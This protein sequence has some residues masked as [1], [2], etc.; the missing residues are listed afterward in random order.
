LRTVGNR[1]SDIIEVETSDFVRIH[2]RTSYSVTFHRDHKD[3]WFNCENYI[4]VMCDH[5]RSIVRSRTRTMALSQLWPQISQVVRDTILGPRAEGSEGRK[6]RFFAENGM[7]VTEVEIL[8]AEIEDSVIAELMKNVQRESVTLTIGDRQAQEK[9]ASMKLRAE[10][11][12]QQMELT[13]AQKQREAQLGELGRRL[14]HEAQLAELRERE[15]VAAEQTR[16]QAEREQA[17][18]KA[19]IAKESLTLAAQ[20]ES[21]A[22]EASAKAGA[23]MTLHNEELD[24]Q[25]RLR[26][27]DIQLLTAQANAIVA[28]RTAVQPQLVEAL[29]ALGDKALLTEVARN[30]NLVSLFR[31]KEAGEIL[32]EVIGGTRFVPALSEALTNKAAAKPQDPSPAAPSPAKK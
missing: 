21:L 3:K 25:S 26:A 30:M 31:G 1:V 4:Q 14:K 20:V 22:K 13:L 27:L 12:R 2:I 32:K 7:L 17:E 24:Y 23:N 9:V 10:L 8:E 28:E 18:V 11:E 19:R 29:T 6:G 15:L 16:L 5:L